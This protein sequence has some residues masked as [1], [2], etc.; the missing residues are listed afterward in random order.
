MRALLGAVAVVVTVTHFVTPPNRTLRES[1][2]GLACRQV[3][4]N[5]Y[6]DSVSEGALQ[7]ARDG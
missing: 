6:F 2:L 4:G 3:Y 1:E 5:I 7:T